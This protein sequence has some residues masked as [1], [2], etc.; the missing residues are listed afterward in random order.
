M[1]PAFQGYRDSVPTFLRFD[2][3]VENKKPTKKEVI[4]L[5][6]DAWKERLAEDQVSSD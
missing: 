2:G 3:P 6:E 5:L 4:H 1:I